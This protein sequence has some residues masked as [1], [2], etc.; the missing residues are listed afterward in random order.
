M[1]KEKK[2]KRI[3][4]K[5]SLKIVGIVFVFLSMVAVIS[6]EYY[7]RGIGMNATAAS[8]GC[9]SNDWVPIG[10]FCIMRDR[11][12]DGPEKWGESAYSCLDKQG[13]RLCTVAEW[14][15]ACRLDKEN[16]ISLDRMGLDEADDSSED[17]AGYEWVGDIENASERKAVVIGRNGCGDIGSEEIN[18]A[19]YERRCCINRERY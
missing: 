5:N 8:E 14:M 18:G 15:E 11:L 1:Q 3:S 7:T 4:K 12:E 16:I 19:K 2:P 17:E 10:D 13:A 9:P 6:L